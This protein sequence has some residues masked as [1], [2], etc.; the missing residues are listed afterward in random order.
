M[1]DRPSLPLETARVRAGGAYE[2]VVFDRLRPEEQAA[3][4]ELLADPGFYGV[5]RPVGEG[6]GHTYRT[7]DRETALL[8]LTCAAPAPLPFFARDAESLEGVTELILDGVLEVEHEG[9]FLAGARAAAILAPPERVAACHR[10]TRLAEEALR[11]ATAL[12]SDQA[13]RIAAFLYD[14]NRAPIS[15]D[16][17]R[18]LTYREAVLEYLG[19]AAGSPRRGELEG[20]WE[21]SGGDGPGGWISFGSRGRRQRRSDV[22]YKLY[23][24]PAVDDLP[25]AFDAVLA[26]LAGNPQAAF[27]VG[28]DAAG[29]FRPDKLVA[30]FGDLES[31][32]AT[33]RRLEEALPGVASQGVP[34][35]SPID[36]EGLLSWGVDPPASSRPLSWQGPDSWRTWLVGQLGALL[37]RG[38][39][40]APADACSFA[41]AR[42]AREGVDVDRWIPAA[43]LF[44]AA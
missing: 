37:A 6:G 3:F 25:R 18:R 41:L 19:H 38:A 40:D 36:A 35:T 23:V 31:L 12:G 29:L 32:L 44:R 2:L 42:L 28:A 21:I 11:Q 16:W 22:T 33:A 39:G 26:V 5:L 7:V 13:P 27:K 9:A 1:P 17:A 24:S 14:F 20:A 4:A 34:F 43:H 10:L 30:Y 8:L 15:P